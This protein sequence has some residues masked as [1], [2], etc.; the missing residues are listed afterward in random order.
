MPQPARRHGLFALAVACIAVTFPTL[1]K[2]AHT[3]SIGAGMVFPDW[4]LSNGSLNPEGWLQN[5]AMFAEHSHRLFAGL[6]GLFT[7]ALLIAVFRSDTARGERRLALV[8]LGL[9]VAQ[10]VLGGLRVL[11]DRLHIA[12][13]DASG[14]VVFS[15]VHACTAQVFMAVLFVL[16]ARLHPGWR[17]EGSSGG[18]LQTMPGAI[19]LGAGAIVALAAVQL[20]VAAVMRHRGAGLAIP[21]FPLAEGGTLL[22]SRWDF[23]VGVHFA[24]RALALAIAIA[25]SFWASRVFGLG[26]RVVDLRRCAVIL[27]IVLVIQIALGAAI[28]WTGRHPVVTSLHVP[29]GASFI[30]TAVLAWVVS[31][32]TARAVAGHAE[33]AEPSR[34]PMAAGHA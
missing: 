16:A 30:A 28:I 27:A 34:H 7:L 4:P 10:G 23:A 22:P 14:G 9:V 29:V 11:L 1:Y 17:T 8:A 5:A 12:V 13:L 25:V 21:T 3:T 26:R 2:G 19:R 18:E 31:G 15:I 33:S 24:H 20:V 32:R 6:A